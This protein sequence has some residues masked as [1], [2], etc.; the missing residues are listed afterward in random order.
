MEI[1]H[2][3][4]PSHWKQVKQLIREYH[5]WVRDEHGIDLGFQGIEAEFRSLPGVYVEPGGC[6]LLA[7]V[8]GK[9]AGCVALRPL[10]NKVCEMKRMFVRPQFRGMGLGKALAEC[11][12]QEAR[13]RKYTS[14]RLDTADTMLAA[15]GLYHSLGFRQVKQYYEL[16]AGVRERAVFMELDLLKD[17]EENPSSAGNP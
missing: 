1:I 13:N 3:S 8:E 2:V 16:P 17:R 6:V 11:I 5:A 15:Q 14:M 7:L 4:L 9:P 10:E 12:V